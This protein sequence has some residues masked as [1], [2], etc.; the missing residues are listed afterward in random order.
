[1]LKRRKIRKL[2]SRVERAT[3][4]YNLDITRPVAVVSHAVYKGAASQ[5]RKA[6]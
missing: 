5:T 3:S 2:T 6:N 1:V 4:Y